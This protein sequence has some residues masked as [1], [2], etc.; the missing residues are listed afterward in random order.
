MFSLKEKQHIAAELEK[1]LLSLKHPEM[2]TERPRFALTVEGKEPWSFADITPNW[3]YETEPPK[4]N[5][6]NE[7]TH[8]EIE[9]KAPIITALTQPSE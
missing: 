2:P 9:A 6:W 4:V 8:G 1:L 3:F 5:P 7:Q